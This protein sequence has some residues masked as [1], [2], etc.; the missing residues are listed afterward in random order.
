MFHPKR[1]ETALSLARETRAALI[2]E[3]VI[4]QVTQVLATQF[5][6]QQ[7]IVVADPRT[8][9]AAGA[10]VQDVLAAAQLADGDP[11][12]LAESHLS[13]EMAFVE[14]VSAALASRSGIPVAVGSGTINDI[15][16]LAAHR[17]GRPY[18][19]VGTA[20]S[21]DG[22]TAF[23]ASITHAGLKQT[24]SCPAPRAVIAD[25]TV[26]RQAP[27][28]ML[29]A[30]YG[31]LLA[32]VVCGADWIVADALGIEPIDAPAWDLVQGGLRGAIDDPAR[33]VRGETAAFAAFVEGLLL[34]GLAMQWHRSS[35]PASGA[36]HQ[37]SHLWD[38][39]HHVHNGAAPAHG[40][41]VGV[42]THFIA[43]LYEQVLLVPFERLDVEQ[44]CA[45]W[46][47]RDAAVAQA[48]AQLG[49][50]HLCDLGATE[51]QAK[52][53]S[54]DALAVELNRLR[55]TWP[56]LKARLQRQLLPAAEMRR[57]LETVGAPSLPES[58]GISRARLAAS[59]PRAQ[60]IR[61]RYTVLDLCLRTA[62]LNP[63]AERAL[64][65][66]Y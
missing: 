51:T 54:R 26:M 7:A 60:L 8:W 53:V 20:A 38:M 1:L 66:L 46:P 35:R 61:R 28:A 57:R 17:L 49:D 15:V 37:F 6:G 63:L 30:G 44:A 14:R 58:I 3:G 16:K 22:Y 12:V 36:E 23:G 10:D 31:D 62:L 43:A 65:R 64:N 29:A 13:A 11:V 33:L 41:K 40:F 56:Q 39:E 50:A 25:L 19:A 55:A 9:R 24:F 47:D 21:M 42:A 32:K 2:G 52:Y 4:K 45:Q 5:P 18:L 48:R 34:G 27:S 59:V